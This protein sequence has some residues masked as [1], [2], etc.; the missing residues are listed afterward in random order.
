LPALIRS[1]DT[2]APPMEMRDI[3]DNGWTLAMIIALLAAEWVVRR[4]SGLV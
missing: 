2:E 3:W 1:A 4:R